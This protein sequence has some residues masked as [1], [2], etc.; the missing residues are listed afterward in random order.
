MRHHAAA[1]VQPGKLAPVQRLERLGFCPHKK[2]LPD[3]IHQFARFSS[4]STPRLF[5]YS[6][7]H[8]CQLII[9]LI[10]MSDQFTMLSEPHHATVFDDYVN[11]RSAKHSEPDVSILASLRHHHPDMT[12][13]VILAQTFNFLGFANAG[14]ATAELNLTE[15]AIIR[16]RG[17][18]PQQSASGRASLIDGI[19]FARYK[20]TWKNLEFILYT[21][22][23]GMNVWVY[24]LFP[25][26]SDETVLS[27]SKATDALVLA[28]G[29]FQYP[30]K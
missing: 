12:V 10:T 9:S 27:N 1:A 4:S 24:V 15:D 30:C 14:Y 28:V 21:A 13:T 25:P 23:A 6:L 11:E 19:L 29:Q 16:I 17:Y 22:R 20:Y 26:D 3:P 8:L 2:P 5:A 18:I 7:S